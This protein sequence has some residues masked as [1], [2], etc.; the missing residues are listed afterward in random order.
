MPAASRLPQGTPETRENLRRALMLSGASAASWCFGLPAPDMLLAMTEQLNHA[1]TLS[2]L[3]H[4]LHVAGFYFDGAMLWTGTVALEAAHRFTELGGTIGEQ[5]AIVLDAISEKIASLNANIGEVKRSS[6]SFGSQVGLALRGTLR[7]L[8]MPVVDAVHSGVTALVERPQETL[9][10]IG[11]VMAKAVEGFGVLKGMQE[12]WNWSMARFSR[13]KKSDPE[14]GIAAEATGLSPQAVTNLTI[15]IALGG[16]IAAERAGQQIAKALEKSDTGV[17]IDPAK[18]EDMIAA[19]ASASEEAIRARERQIARAT[20]MFLADEGPV[21]RDTRKRPD[22]RMSEAQLLHASREANEILLEA[23][24]RKFDIP[25]D[26]LEQGQAFLPKSHICGSVVCA[27]ASSDRVYPKA[28]PFQKS[29]SYGETGIAAKNEI[30]NNCEKQ[31]SP[32]IM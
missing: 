11:S 24:S 8:A 4:P 27:R 21:F 10:A 13:K 28:D 3:S 31:R 17:I 19:A 1:L 6:V 26:V 32:S 30:S 22:N 16:D 7:D 25:E 23:M 5:T 15:N 29:S 18:V 20:D 9:N 12:V 2:P 14:T